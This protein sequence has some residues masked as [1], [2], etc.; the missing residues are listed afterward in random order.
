MGAL[1]EEL[2]RVRVQVIDRDTGKMATWYEAPMHFDKEDPQDR[3]SALIAR[4]PL[5]MS[6]SHT[7]Y[8]N[9]HKP[10][11]DHHQLRAPGQDL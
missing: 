8:H 4:Q 1:C 10:R 9:D 7:R 3:D 2:V 11:P 5:T 6:I